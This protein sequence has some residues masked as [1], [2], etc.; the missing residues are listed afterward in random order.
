LCSRPLRA[1]LRPMYFREPIPYLRR[2]GK[3]R[4]RSL[5]RREEFR[6][7]PRAAVLTVVKVAGELGAVLAPASVERHCYEA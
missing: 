3:Y 4:G 5:L 6:A 7:P 2:I 1:L